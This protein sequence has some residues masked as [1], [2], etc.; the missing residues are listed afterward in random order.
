MLLVLTLKQGGST[1]QQKRL[2]KDPFEEAMIEKY[3]VDKITGSVTKVEESGVT[4]EIEEGIDGVI[5]KDKIP[6]TMTF[7]VGQSVIATVSE[8]D[9]KRLQI[10]LTSC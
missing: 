6:P 7:T 8:H 10:S 4:I 2:T 1:S 9:K 3:P 5:K